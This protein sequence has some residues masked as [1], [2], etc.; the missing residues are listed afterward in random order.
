M[1]TRTRSAK[2]NETRQTPGEIGQGSTVARDSNGDGAQNGRQAS[3]MYP[4]VSRTKLARVTGKDITTISQILRGRHKPPFDTALKIAGAV[5][6]SPEELCRD[7]ERQNEKFR[8]A[9]RSR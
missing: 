9:R 5:G 2:T 3:G 1:G 8:A 7:W 4:Q 6:V